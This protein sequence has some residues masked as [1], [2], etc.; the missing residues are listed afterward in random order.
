[1]GGGVCIEVAL[2]GITAFSFCISYGASDANLLPE[3]RDSTLRP[4]ITGLGRCVSTSLLFK[5]IDV[6]RELVGSIWK[7]V[8]EK[9]IFGK[10]QPPNKIEP[11]FPTTTTTAKEEKEWAIRGGQ[12]ETCQSIFQLGFVL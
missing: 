1:M 5:I 9:V 7:L 8:R 2:P 3:K 11:I 4:A 6:S 12:R 10:Y